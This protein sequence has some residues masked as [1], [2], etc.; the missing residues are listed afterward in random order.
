MNS[1]AWHPGKYLLAYAGDEIESKTG[2]VR[3]FGF[4]S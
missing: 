3:V 4:S 1:I 2:I